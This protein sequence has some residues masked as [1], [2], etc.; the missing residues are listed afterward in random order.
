M[1]LTQN[2]EKCPE[3]ETHGKAHNL[4]YFYIS[5]EEAIYKCSNTQCL[6]PFENFIFKDLKDNSVYYYEEVGE[7]GENVFCK[8]LTN[9]KKDE[10][11]KA[12][13]G[14]QL[15]KT[16]ADCDI[17]S[18]NED[19]DTFFEQL[20]AENVDPTPSTSA[21]GQ[22]ALDSAYQPSFF[23][24][25][26]VETTQQIQSTIEN[27]P[28]E[29]YTAPANFFDFLPER[30]VSTPK[31]DREAKST[32]NDNQMDVV[33]DLLDLLG[34]NG[35]SNDT[36]QLPVA[37]PFYNHRPAKKSSTTKSKT[38]KALVVKPTKQTSTKITKSNLPAP[39]LTKCIEMIEKSK[40]KR[41]LKGTQKSTDIAQQVIPKPIKSQ[42]NQPANI[43]EDK[44]KIVNSWRLHT[45]P[46]RIV[47]QFIAGNFTNPQFISNLIANNKAHSPTKLLDVIKKTPIMV[48]PATIVSGQYSRQT[49]RSE[50]TKPKQSWDVV[51]NSLSL[52]Q[53]EYHASNNEQLAVDTSNDSTPTLPAEMPIVPAEIPIVP[54]EI[55]IV[56]AENPVVLALSGRGKTKRSEGN[57]SHSRKRKSN[58]DNL[59]GS[60]T[61][62]KPII[63]KPRVRSSKGKKVE[64]TG[65]SLVAVKTGMSLPSAEKSF[66]YF[67]DYSIDNYNFFFRAKK[68]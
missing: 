53:F 21:S 12:L 56:P 55:P 26:V 9:G 42:F 20:F 67:R 27:I 15:D 3:C 62:N 66:S 54:A 68:L 58:A 64:D 32:P 45:G 39:K 60:T 7:K 24:Q 11:Q 33:D 34:A 43:S 35:G 10:S 5:L 29:D 19:M 17:E 18:Y 37:N 63:K 59:D 52:P 65:T 28:N 14:S 50:I 38:P 49:Q 13:W 61:E 46:S 25:N 16:T 41:S 6:Y 57:G 30:T 1:L 8:L 36:P 23:E 47:Q 44:S 2:T 51:L 31:A 40:N 48:K 4:R 22:L